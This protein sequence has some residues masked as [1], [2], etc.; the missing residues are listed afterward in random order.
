MRSNYKPVRT[1]C[2]ALC[3]NVVPGVLMTVKVGV[4]SEVLSLTLK[5]IWHI[6]AE[7]DEMQALSGGTVVSRS[8]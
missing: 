7:Y 6:F 4:I 8:I 2:S 1:R 5:H 3:H